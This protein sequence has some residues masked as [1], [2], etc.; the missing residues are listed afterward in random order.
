MP[1][2]GMDA[3][4]AQPAAIISAALSNGAAFSFLQHFRQIG[5]PRTAWIV[6]VVRNLLWAVGG[7]FTEP[8][9]QLSIAATL[10]DQTIKTIT[11]RARALLT[12]DV[13]HIELADQITEYDR[14]VTGH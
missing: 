14:A 1:S 3:I 13:Q 12:V 5:T 4:I 6:H 10:L 2:R 7:D 9:D 8:V 11:T